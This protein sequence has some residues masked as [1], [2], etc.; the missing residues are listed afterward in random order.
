MSYR[1]VS[2]DRRFRKYSK[3]VRPVIRKFLESC[4]GQSGT[5][6]G[7]GRTRAPE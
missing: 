5:A 1:H 3:P 2:D 7:K 6:R 4:D